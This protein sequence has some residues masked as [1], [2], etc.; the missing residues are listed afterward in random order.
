M[1]NLLP[2]GQLDGG[3]VA[4]ALLGERQNRISPKVRWALLPLFV[5]NLARFLVPVL[6]HPTGGTIAGAVGNSLFWLVWFGVLGVLSR[7]SGGD[8]PPYEDGEL[9]GFRKAIGWLCVA[10]FVGLFMPTPLSH[11]E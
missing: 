10:L 4:Y 9:S 2:F 3:H 1:I 11:I 7:V 6:R 5:L 8:H